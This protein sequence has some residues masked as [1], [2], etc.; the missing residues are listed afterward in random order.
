MEP[1]PDVLAPARDGTAGRGWVCTSEG[2]WD[3]IWDG[4]RVGS[5]VGIAPTGSMEGWYFKGVKVDDT[6]RKQRP[7][8]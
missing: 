5:R 1:G 6:I 7:A 8:R 4:M 2:S 3:G